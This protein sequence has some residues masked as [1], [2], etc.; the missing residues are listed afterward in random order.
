M[1]LGGAL[2][3][4]GGITGGLALGKN[5]DVEKACEDGVCY[6]DD[7]G[8]LDSRDGLATASTV[9]IVSGGV[10]A[11]TGIVLLIAGR[12]GEAQGGSVALLPGPGGLV[13][14]GRF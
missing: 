1:G 2:L 6:E 5:G 4:G 3:V 10:L 8:L 11:A 13:F 7:Y 9:L 14:R 12:G